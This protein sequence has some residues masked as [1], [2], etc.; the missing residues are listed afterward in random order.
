VPHRGIDGRKRHVEKE[1]TIEGRIVTKSKVKEIS[2]VND[3]IQIPRRPDRKN[4]AP[5]RGKKRIL[6]SCEAKSKEKKDR[7]RFSR[8]RGDPVFWQIRAEEKAN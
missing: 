3:T 7:E 8:H 6:E 2:W 5:Y 4:I 1:L